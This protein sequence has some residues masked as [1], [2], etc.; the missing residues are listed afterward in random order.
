MER[1]DYWWQAFNAT[2]ETMVNNWNPWCN[3]NVLTCFLLIEKDKDALAQGVYRTMASVDKYLDYTKYDG[4]CEE[5]PSYWGHAYG[6]L[7]DYLQILNYATGEN[8]PVFDEPMI[9]NMGE[10]IAQSYIGDGWVVNFADASAKASPPE[11]VIFRYGEAVGS[12]QMQ[13][14]ASYLYQRDE[15]QDYYFARS[16]IFRTLENLLTLP[17][18]VE[19]EPSLPSDRH[20]WYPQTE[21]C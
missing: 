4:A 3:F 7:Y 20:V 15:G 14:F 9:R 13:S 11:G 10:Y 19:K 6:K 8:L 17:S 12:E 1:D 2:P 5:G 16:D 18:I 21:F